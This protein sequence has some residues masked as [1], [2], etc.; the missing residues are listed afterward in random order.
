MLVV[1]PSAPQ[2]P[3]LQFVQTPNS[4][5][6]PAGHDD[7]DDAPA[8]HEYPGA[9]F[10]HVDMLKAP[11]FGDA[12]PTK[13]KIHVSLEVAPVVALHVPAGHFVVLPEIAGQ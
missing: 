13:H 6:C 7:K 12:V 1:S 5:D 2:Y 4:A 9:H 11:I 3:A 10:I 8:G